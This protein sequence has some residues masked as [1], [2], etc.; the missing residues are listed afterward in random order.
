MQEKNSTYLQ[1]GKGKTKGDIKK[2]SFFSFYKTNAKETLVDQKTY[3]SF[4]KDLLENFSIAI[5]KEALELKINKVG[6][7]RIKSNPLKFFNKSGEKY[8]SLRVNWQATWENWKL[9]YPN[10]TKEEIT[11]ISDK[12]VIYHENEHSNQEFYSYYWDKATINLKYKTF[13]NF[14]ASRQYL[15]LIAQVVKDPNRKVFYYG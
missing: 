4:I 11:K 8:K 9:K 10:L 7:L 6:K 5:V 3:N 15:R 1:R 13:Y 2:A 14:K 12:K